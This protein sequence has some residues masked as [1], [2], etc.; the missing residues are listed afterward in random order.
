MTAAKPPATAE[1]HHRLGHDRSER[2][3]RLIDQLELQLSELEETEAEEEVGPRS[4]QWSSSDRREPTAPAS[5]LA[6]RCRRA[7][8]A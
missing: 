3:R 2:G 5:R 8:R 7:C 6:D 4:P 1:L